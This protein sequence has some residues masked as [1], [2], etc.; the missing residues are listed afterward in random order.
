MSEEPPKESQPDVSQFAK[1]KNLN[2]WYYGLPDYLKDPA[3]Y[4]KI[5][6]LIYETL[7]SSCSHGEVMEW[8]S[9]VKCQKR[10]FERNSVLKHLGFSNPRQYLNWKKV[11]NLIINKTRQPLV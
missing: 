6:K 8:A 5:E 3:H 1:A 10:F 9:C 2:P 4:Y 7:A 11:M